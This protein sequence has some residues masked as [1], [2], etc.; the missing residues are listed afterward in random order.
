[1]TSNLRKLVL[2]AHVAT[3]VG[4]LGAVIA[5]LALAIA[6][7]TSKEAQT[8]RASFLSMELVGWFVIV[9][10]GLAALLTGLVQSLVTEWGLFRHYWILAKF[11]LTIGGITI[12][13]MHMPVV[14]RLAGVAAETPIL[15]AALVGLPHPTF[16]VHAGGGLLVLLTA[17]T[18]S[19]YKPWGLTPYGRCV[20]RPMPTP[21]RGWSRRQRWVLFVLI[22]IIGLVVLLGIWHLIGGGLPG[23]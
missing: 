11:L 4:W 17:T 7:L 15:N 23:H 21:D 3:S 16:V 1:M 5:Y 14:S 6:A 18:L 12:L 20:S 22:G 2:T 9:P 13:L 8:V 19:V 10:C